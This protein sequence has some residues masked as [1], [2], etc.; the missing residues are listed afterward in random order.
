MMDK[1]IINPHQYF[2]PLKTMFNF[3]FILL[4]HPKLHLIS[5]SLI[6]IF[7]TLPYTTDRLNKNGIIKLTACRNRTT[8]YAQ[9]K[10][11]I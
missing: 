8:T 1:D 5:L 6:I 2:P 10:P 3:K 4:L 9:I 7:E 11:I